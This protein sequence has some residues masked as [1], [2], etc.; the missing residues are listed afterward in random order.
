MDI[1]KYIAIRN[2]LTSKTYPM[3][4][5]SD[6]DKKKIQNLSRK[7][8]VNDGKLFVKEKQGNIMGAEVLHSLNMEDVIQ[9][10]HAEGHFGINNTWR[11]L[12]LQ[13]EGNQLYEKVREFVKTCP[14][15]QL[16]SRRRKIKQEPAHP[17]PTPSRP[18]FMI[19]CDAVGPMTTTRQ[20][21]SYILVGID[22]LTRWPVAAAVPNINETTTADF[23][24]NC[25][26]K[27]FGVPNYIL[28]DRGSNF[29]S[30]HVGFFL[31]KMGCRHLTTTAYQPR[32]NGLCERMNQTIVQALSK[33]AR[34]KKKRDRW[35]ECLG[36]AI[37][38]IRTMPNDATKISPAML[39]FGYEMRTPST[40]P[41]PRVD[42]VEGEI[43]EAVD[44]RI[45][46]IQGLMEQQRKEAVERSLEKKKLWKKKYDVDVVKKR[47]EVGDQVLLLDN[48]KAEKL[49]DCWLGPFVVTKVN[50]NG[51]YWLIGKDQRRLQGAINVE[52]L[53]PWNQRKSLVPMV[54][55]GPLL[56]FMEKK[57]R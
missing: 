54:S 4:C 56:E 21:N 18:F 38:A 3:G 42:Y 37:M 28:T 11:R 50:N 22:Y 52:K 17:I 46:I 19:G 41:A 51:T 12:R 14:T 43:Q 1:A 34:D 53:R 10:V 31:K 29:L 15:C 33:I 36:E 39:L 55:S 2:Y 47:Y 16:R 35:D 40:W 24:F 57:R 6:K 48:N 26:V 7:Y 25:V 5:D 32:T 23:L 30:R 49:D 27:D 20:G 45:E 8:L 13:Y 9:M 44:Q